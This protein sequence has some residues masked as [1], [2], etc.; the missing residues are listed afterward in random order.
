MDTS[1]PHP[2]RGAPIF[3]VDDE[4]EDVFLIERRLQ[5]TGSAHPLVTFRD[6]EELIEYCDRPEGLPSPPCLLLLD[7]KMPKIDGFDVLKW[8]RASDRLHSVPVA[9]ITSSSRAED[10]TRAL[11]AGANTYFEKFPTTEELAT[12]VAQAS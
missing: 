12:V 5:K 7:L 3:I 4:P 10:R 11:D 1:A 2:P 9:V 6:G 8:I